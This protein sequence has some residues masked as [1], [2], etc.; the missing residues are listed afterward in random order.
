MNTR[1]YHAAPRSM[2]IP[3]SAMVGTALL[4]P[5]LALAARGPQCP[6]SSRL[7]VVSLQRTGK[8]QR[9]AWRLSQG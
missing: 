9:L 5:P 7:A 6:L 8:Y 2:P 1:A 3:V 4:F